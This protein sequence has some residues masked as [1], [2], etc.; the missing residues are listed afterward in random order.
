MPFPADSRPGF[1]TLHSNTWHVDSR[2]I[3]HSIVQYSTVAVHVKKE[4]NNGLECHM[5]LFLSESQGIYYSGEQPNH[6]HHQPK[7]DRLLA[8]SL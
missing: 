6:L 7:P 4:S 1:A 5:R 3:I 8:W 2:D